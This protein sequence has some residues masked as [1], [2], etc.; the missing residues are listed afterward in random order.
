LAGAGGGVADDAGAADDGDAAAGGT[1]AAAGGTDAAA[2]GAGVTPGDDTDEASG[3]APVE[4]V[5]GC[6]AATLTKLGSASENGERNVMAAFT[7]FGH[8][9]SGDLVMMCMPS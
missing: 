6:P 1:D 4:A 3:A 7:I 9:E 2:A 8:R 5:A